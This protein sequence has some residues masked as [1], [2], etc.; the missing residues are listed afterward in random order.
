MVKPVESKE[1]ICFSLFA[2]EVQ[3][4]SNSHRNC[5]MS[6][7]NHKNISRY[8]HTSLQSNL[9][10]FYVEVAVIAGGSK[11]IKR[12]KISNASNLHLQSSL[13]PPPKKKKFTDLDDSCQS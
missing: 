12:F 6:Q 13:P 3:L 11:N 10:K 9:V 8:Y 1:E 2:F 7:K 4:L 5:K